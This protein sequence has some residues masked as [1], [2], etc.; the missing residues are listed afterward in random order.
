[1]YQRLES[2]HQLRVKLNLRT[3]EH[4]TRSTGLGHLIYHKGRV[5]LLPVAKLY[6]RQPQLHILQ[7]APIKD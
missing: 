7:S 4:R 5:A 3:L 2:I 1:M 6:E